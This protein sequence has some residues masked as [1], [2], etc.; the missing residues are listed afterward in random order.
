MAAKRKTSKTFTVLA[1]R[2]ARGHAPENTLPAFDKAIALGAKWM[3]L[4][5]QWHDGELWVLHDLRLDR[6]TN[7]RGWLTDFKRAELRALDAGGG[8]KIPLLAEVIERVNRRARLN[9]EMKTAEG[10][11]AALAACLRRFIARG[12]RADDF[13]VSSFHL[14]ELRDFHRRMPEVPMLALL[15]GVPLQLAAD[16]HGLGAGVIGIDFDFVDAGLVKDAHRRG[17]KVFVYTVNQA[18]DIRRL[19][20]RGIDGV[21]TDYPDRA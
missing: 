17:L 5:V 15:C 12:W 1:H 11:A 8:A 7:G 13:M 16:A 20:A 2:G 4:D 9:I 18:E 19:R 6:T 3:E 14:P 21:F 10:T